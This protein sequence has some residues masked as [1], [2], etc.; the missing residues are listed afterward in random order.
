MDKYLNNEMDREKG[1][2]LSF[3]K[4]PTLC[5]EFHLKDGAP[6]DPCTIL[7][8]IFKNLILHFESQTIEQQFI[9]VITSI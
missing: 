7:E 3:W 2:G 4:W 6:P 8:Y 1:V 5:Y 9:K